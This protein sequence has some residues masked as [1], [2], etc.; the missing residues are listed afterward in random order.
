MCPDLLQELLP[1]KSTEF[2]CGM[3]VNC[4]AGRNCLHVGAVRGK[5]LADGKYDLPVSKRE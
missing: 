5:F 3:F 4:R 2:K 1:T